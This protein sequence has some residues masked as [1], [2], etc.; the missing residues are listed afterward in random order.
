[1]RERLLKQ[2][3]PN[4]DLLD[5]LDILEVPMDNVVAV[6]KCIHPKYDIQ[7]Q[8]D[9]FLAGDVAGL[10]NPSDLDLEFIA[11]D[12][13]VDGSIKSYNL[14][15]TS[16][17]EYFDNHLTVDG[18]EIRY[19][20]IL[21]FNA[22]GGFEVVTFPT[23][24]DTAIQKKLALAKQVV[25]SYND[26]DFANP[27]AF[28]QYSVKMVDTAKMVLDVEDLI[29]TVIEKVDDLLKEEKRERKEKYLTFKKPK[30]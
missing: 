10:K 8:V 11:S 12:K 6:L 26:I 29:Q 18:V 1:L 14:L 7:V 27:L 21:G 3:N 19:A 5:R 2:L 20:S 16:R 28:K 25:E 4:S 15:K 30:K 22:V 17:V 23:R 24:L 9:S 13:V